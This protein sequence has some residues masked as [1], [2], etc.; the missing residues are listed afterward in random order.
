MSLLVFIVAT[1]CPAG[2][3][4]PACSYVCLNPF[5]GRRCLK[6]CDCTDVQR[7]DPAIG[8]TDQIISNMPFFPSVSLFKIELRIF[9][10]NL[11]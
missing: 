9:E 8:C 2:T 10:F 3:F 11:N 5:Y 6:I 4:G 7:C 1:D